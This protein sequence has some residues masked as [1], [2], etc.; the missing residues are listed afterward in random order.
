[1]PVATKK[2][3][4]F[5]AKPFLKWAG[6]KSRL[7][8]QY[9]PLFPQVQYPC[10]HE[11][12]LG[13]GAVFFRLAP[14]QA[15]L[16]DSN[17]ELIEAYRAIRDRCPELMEVLKRIPLG[18]EAYYTVRKMDPMAMSALERAARTI[19]LNR[20]CYNGLFRVNRHGQFNVPY[21]QYA[22][23]SI[24]NEDV[25]FAAESALQGVEI[26]HEDF[27]GVLARAKT[28][29]F[30][31]FDPPY[32]PVS[33]T[34][35]FT[36]YTSGAFNEQEQRRLFDVFTELDRRGCLVMLSNSATPF[37]EALYDDYPRVKVTAKR[38]INCQ[39]AKRGDVCEL[40]I[41]NY[42]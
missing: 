36:A 31:Y 23:P 27:S 42:Q 22:K 15:V 41:R 3:Q 34:A 38:V 35:Y 16:S 14:G 5:R 26:C 40:V 10:Y 6:G 33:S 25:L 28:G 21:G 32:H 2:L 12:F 7:L 8:R 11:P 4:T 30:I 24:F 1:M 19:Y 20:T 29:D 17:H 18:R 37:I 13:G 9:E 39:S